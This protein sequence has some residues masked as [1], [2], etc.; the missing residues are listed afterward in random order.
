M[1][2]YHF[3]GKLKLL[4][5][6]TEMTKRKTNENLSDGLGQAQNCDGV[7]LVNCRCQHSLLDHQDLLCSKVKIT[8]MGI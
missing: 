3:Y 1:Y 7:K 5:T 8:V 4:N 2:M 6:D